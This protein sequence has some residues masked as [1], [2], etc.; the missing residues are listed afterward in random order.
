MH[1]HHS[2]MCVAKVK[3]QEMRHEFCVWEQEQDVRPWFTG[4]CHR[5]SWGVSHIA[6]AVKPH[7][8]PRGQTW[9]RGLDVPQ[10]S[11]SQHCLLSWRVFGLFELSGSECCCVW[12]LSVHDDTVSSHIFDLY[13]K[14]AASRTSN[15]FALITNWTVYGIKLS[16]WN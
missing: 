11:F 2:F 4:M 1:T 8:Y 10:V 5:G 7:L 14:A 12:T 9:R 3:G 13:Q 15:L 6:D 16:R